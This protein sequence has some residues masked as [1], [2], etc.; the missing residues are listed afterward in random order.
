LRFDPNP[1]LP[2]TSSDPCSPLPFLRRSPISPGL[3]SR[4]LPI[5]HPPTA[6]TSN[7]QPILL[8]LLRAIT[9]TRPKRLHRHRVHLPATTGKTEHVGCVEGRTGRG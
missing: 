4:H 7:R 9:R 6:S 3:P 8:G 2:T 5:A 1:I